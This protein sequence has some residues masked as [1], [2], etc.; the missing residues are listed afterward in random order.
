MR[1][2]KIVSDVR[3]H[4]IGGLMLPSVPMQIP[5]EGLMLGKYLEYLSW[6]IEVQVVATYLNE[7][8]QEGDKERHKASIL[9]AVAA[10]SLD[11]GA[12]MQEL[13]ELFG[14]IQLTARTAKEA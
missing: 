2:H 12:M 14:L 5:V 7:R 10:G 3:N 6:H 1:A 13:T 11:L 4:Q 9:K 8:K